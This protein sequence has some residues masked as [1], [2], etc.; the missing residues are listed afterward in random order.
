MNKNIVLIGMMGSGKSMVAKVLHKK[1][2][3][4]LFSVDKLIE[5]KAH[6][7][8]KEIF[9]KHGEVYFR[10]LEHEVIV[11]LAAKQGI[12]IDGG[13]GVVVNPENVAVLKKNGI[14]FFLDATPDVI[15]KRIKGDPKRPLIAGPNPLGR[16]S[17]L[18]TERFPLYS[19][20][21]DHVI[22]ANDVTIERPVAQILARIK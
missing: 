3:L 14:L 20:A 5:K 19:Q 21:A 9:A 18:H 13:G 15:Y 22:D 12:I 6:A 2:G 10:Q 4:P 8:I 17:Q 11:E 1:T 7:T 16:I